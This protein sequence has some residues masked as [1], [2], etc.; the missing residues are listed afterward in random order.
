MKTIQLFIKDWNMRAYLH[1]WFRRI[2]SN[3]NVDDI[4]AVVTVVLLENSIDEGTQG[5]Q[6]ET[7]EYYAARLRQNLHC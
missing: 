5:L 2:K 6:G 7:K 1:L 3:Q 4:E